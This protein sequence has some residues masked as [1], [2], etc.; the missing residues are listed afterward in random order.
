MTP[1]ITRLPSPYK[2]KSVSPSKKAAT[3]SGPRP[4]FKIVERLS[5]APLPDSLMSADDLFHETRLL[6]A[7]DADGSWTDED[8]V[9]GS[10]R[11]ANVQGDDEGYEGK[12][13]TLRDILLQAGTTTQFD[14]LS[15]AVFLHCFLSLR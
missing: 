5:L 8:E 9:P 12:S 10:D 15:V 3:H 6:C 2:F 11:G 14:L 1:K 7:S 13:I 4:S